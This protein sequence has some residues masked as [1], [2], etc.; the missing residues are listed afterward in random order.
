MEMTVKF[1]KID[2]A[3]ESQTII[4][5]DSVQ[6]IPNRNWRFSSFTFTSRRSI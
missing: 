2:K 5:E 1:H 6:N 3:E 4:D